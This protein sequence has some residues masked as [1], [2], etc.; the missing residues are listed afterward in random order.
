[1]FPPGVVAELLAPKSGVVI[2][3]T[4]KSCPVAPAAGRFSTDSPCDVPLVGVIEAHPATS[5]TPDMARI[6][7]RLELSGGLG[8]V[9]HSRKSLPIGPSTVYMPLASDDSESTFVY[10]VAPVLR[11]RVTVHPCFAMSL[12]G[13]EGSTANAPLWSRSWYTRPV[14]G[15][16]QD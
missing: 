5:V 1:M 10:V 2:G 4:A 16:L 13:D 14:M 11:C 8:A 6:P 7:H 15:A 9:T 12:V 3:T